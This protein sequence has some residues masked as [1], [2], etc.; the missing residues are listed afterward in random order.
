M[1]EAGP[2]GD[3]TVTIKLWWPDAQVGYQLVQAAQRTFLGARQVAETTAISEIDR[4]ARAVFR[5]VAPEHRSRVDPTAEDAGDAPGC[6]RKVAARRGVNASLAGAE[7]AALGTALADVR[8]RPATSEPETELDRA[9]ALITAKRQELAR[10]EDTRQRQLAALQGQLTQLTTVYTA[11]HPSVIAVQQNI[12]ALSHE[13]TQLASVKADLKELEAEYQPAI[14][15][16]P[17]TNESER[18]WPAG[19]PPAKR[20]TQA[21]SPSQRLRRRQQHGRF[22]NRSGRTRDR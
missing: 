21:R 19:R 20:H 11:S 6:R 7:R 15:S 10:L 18:S 9:K 3:G 13:P 12:E 17:P 4:G 14:R 22:E 1:V 16:K 5:V 2:V 8:P